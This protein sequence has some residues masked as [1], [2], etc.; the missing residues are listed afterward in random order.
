MQEYAYKLCSSFIAALVL[1]SGLLPPPPHHHPPHA[2]GPAFAPPGSMLVLFGQLPLSQPL[3]QYSQT[4]R[5]SSLGCGGT[6][7]ISGGGTG[8]AGPG[9]CR[10][11]RTAAFRAFE[12]AFRASAR[13]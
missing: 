2:R 3:S 6:G 5:V 8:G 7:A 4:A 9:K 13:T 10:K 12:R 11:R 1:T